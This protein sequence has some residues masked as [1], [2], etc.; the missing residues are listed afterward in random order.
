MVSISTRLKI[1]LIEA[2]RTAWMVYAGIGQLIA[3]VKLSDV[4][5]KMKVYIPTPEEIKQWKEKTQPY[6]KEYLVKKLGKDLVE[7]FL[8]VVEEAKQKIM[9]EVSSTG[10]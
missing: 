1:A 4:R 9:V 5:K 6:V 10:K 2:E 3:D 7:R 8:K